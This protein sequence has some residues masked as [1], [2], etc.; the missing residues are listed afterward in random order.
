M[1]EQYATEGV[2]SDVLRRTPDNAPMSMY[3]GRPSMAISKQVD[4]P[5]NQLDSHQA[6][7]SCRPGPGGTII[8]ARPY[9][10][11]IL[12]LASRSLLD[13]WWQWLS[14]HRL[15]GS[16]SSEK[17]II[18]PSSF[19]NASKQPFSSKNCLC[20]IQSPLT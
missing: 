8:P 2:P 5:V 12:N 1:E 3:P 17:I 6:P 15:Y 11:E 18:F 13:G 16:F 7:E 10:E 14:F 19:P 4:Q 9:T 20:V